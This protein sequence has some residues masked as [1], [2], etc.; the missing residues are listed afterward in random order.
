GR[1]QGHDCWRRAPGEP[2]LG[3]RPCEVCDVRVIYESDFGATRLERERKQIREKGLH[4]SE[5]TRRGSGQAASR[6]SWSEADEAHAGAGCVYW[7]SSRRSLQ[8]V[9]LQ[10]LKN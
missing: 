2:G 6:S 1:R 8:S 3:D 5:K 7:S 10:V 4:A 9:A